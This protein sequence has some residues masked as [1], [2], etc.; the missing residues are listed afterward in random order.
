MQ[1]GKKGGER[2]V[3]KVVMVE[4]FRLNKNSQIGTVTGRS[5]LSV[6]PVL[7]RACVRPLMFIIERREHMQHLAK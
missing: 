3:Q 2:P 1:S 5:K 4:M 7:S 6:H